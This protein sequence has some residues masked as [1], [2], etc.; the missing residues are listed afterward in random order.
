MISA[1]KR[2]RLNEMGGT[3]R[4]VGT[5]SSYLPLA[6]NLTIPPAEVRYV[7]GD[8]HSNAP[9]VHAMCERTGRTLVASQYGAY[10]HRDAGFEVRRVFHKVRSVAIENFN[11]QFK[12]IFDA[13]AQVPTRGL[14]STRRF[15]LGAVLVYQLMLLH[16][17]EQQQPLRVGLKTCLLAA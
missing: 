11:E 8:R 1:G 12:A 13:H 15:A 14:Q 9:D 4:T 6:L 16:R 17:F 3:A 7:L 5:R 2:W 10:P